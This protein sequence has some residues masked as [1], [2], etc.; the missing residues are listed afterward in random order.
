MLVILKSFGDDNYSVIWYKRYDR[1]IAHRIFDIDR[2]GKQEILV[3]MK[4]TDASRTK[5]LSYNI[6]TTTVEISASI[7]SFNISVFPNPVSSSAT[8]KI[9]SE[10]PD[11]IQVSVWSIN[12]RILY[13]RDIAVTPGD[14]N[15]MNLPIGNTPDGTYFVTTTDGRTQ[16]AMKF[17]IMR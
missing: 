3:S 9:Y 14:N 17:L 1:G 5:I 2:D 6:P 11:I 7:N 15:T 4:E 16:R 13:R 8:L 10:K 12:G